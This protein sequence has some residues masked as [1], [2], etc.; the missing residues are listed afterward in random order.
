MPACLESATAARVGRHHVDVLVL[1]DCSPD[2]GWSDD[3]RS[4]CEALEFGYYRSPHDLGLPRTMNLALARAVSGGYDHVFIVSSDVVMPVNLVTAM[5]QV[6][7]ANVGIG[8]VT[9]WSN[10]VSVFSIPNHDVT[11]M[12]ERQD[13][14]NWISAE[15]EREFGSSAVDIPAGSGF[16][17]LI[18][19]PVVAKV[20]LFDPLYGP[21]GCEE[22]D[23]CLR[24]RTRGYRAVLAPS[25]FVFRHA[26]G[27]T[28]PAGM[29]AHEANRVANHERIIALRY[30][31]YE[32]D[33]DA[34][35]DSGALEPLVERAMRTI[36]LR[37]ASRFGYEVEAT[38]V[39][40][41]PASDRVRFV[42]DPVGHSPRVDIEFCGFRLT[43]DVPD[44]DL[45]ALLMHM[46]GTSPSLVTV[47]DRGPFAD[48][49]AA[50]WDGKVPFEDR[51]AYPQRV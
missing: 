18:P 46:V 12:L 19:V 3:V 24:S 10:N 45:V 23:W 5:I 13:T 20:G 2:E 15:L 44:R 25:A 8:S 14:V 50:A 37:A 42:V 6:T 40:E 9:A 29:L 38:W 39:P 32:A 30:P 28:V 27:R 51:C 31:W 48:Q 26:R 21:G 7:E 34:F 33:R 47:H 49:L 41:P 35:L 36:I 22:M 4:M 43:V 1:D 17:L 11:G 16:C